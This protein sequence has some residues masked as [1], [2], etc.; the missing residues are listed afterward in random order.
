LILNH[1]IA[2]ELEE[3]EKLKKKTFFNITPAAW[4][5]TE[6]LLIP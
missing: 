5:Q 1:Y 2:G 6:N 4:L 3:A